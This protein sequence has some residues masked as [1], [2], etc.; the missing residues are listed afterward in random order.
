[1]EDTRDSKEASTLNLVAAQVGSRSKI[2]SW[3]PAIE[4]RADEA[5]WER[6]QESA[7]QPNA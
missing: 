7:L 6:A 1:M 3:Q 4:I 2:E 5:V